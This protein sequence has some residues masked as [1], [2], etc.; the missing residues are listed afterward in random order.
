[1]TLGAILAIDQGTTNTKALLIAPDGAIVARA[2]RP[3]QV[4]YPRPG[5]AEQS[6]A[7]IWNSVAEVVAQVAAD[8]H[9]IAGVGISNQRESAVLWDAA[10]GQALGPCVLWQC[11]RSAPRCEALKAEGYE[12]DVVA[13]T[14]LERLNRVWRAPGMLPTIAELERPDAWLNRTDPD[15]LAAA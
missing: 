5:W 15:T 3:T 11:G 7:D 14:G 6:A 9:V 1:M 10:T 4:S 13:R 12:P 8:G 2:S